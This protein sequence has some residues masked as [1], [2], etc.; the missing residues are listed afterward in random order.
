MLGAALF[1]RKLRRALE[2]DQE[3]VVLN[4]QRLSEMLIAVLARD[5]DVIRQ[6]GKTADL[7]V[8][9][10]RIRDKLVDYCHVVRR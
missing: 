4:D 3:Y 5:Q 6:F 2:I 1:E 8:P 9:G 10:D 7:I